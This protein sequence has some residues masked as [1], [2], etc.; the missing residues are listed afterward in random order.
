[1]QNRLQQQHCIQFIFYRNLLNS[2]YKFNDHIGHTPYEFIYMEKK[3]ITILIEQSSHC[4]CKF[5]YLYLYL[6]KSKKQHRR[7]K[8]KNSI[9]FI[10]V[11]FFVPSHLNQYRFF[12]IMFSVFF[13]LFYIQ[14]QYWLRLFG[15]SVS[16]ID[17]ETQ[18]LS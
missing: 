10:G 7:Q 13:Y 12:F 2:Y 4:N 5:L 6:L 15:N 3:C 1:M 14:N 8:T 9:Q 16:S 17:I 18:R 11:F